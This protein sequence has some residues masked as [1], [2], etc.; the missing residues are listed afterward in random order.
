MF[1]QPLPDPATAYGQPMPTPSDKMLDTMLDVRRDP[2]GDP[3]WILRDD[4]ARHFQLTNVNRREQNRIKRA[5]KEIQMVSHW[6]NAHGLLSELQDDMFAGDILLGKSRGDKPDQMRERAW[7]HS[8]FQGIISKE[9]NVNK[10]AESKGWFG[11]WNKG[12]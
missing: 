12:Q 4:N 6:P 2:G 7:W 11:F 8:F 5:M 1:Q 3:I 9:G 10:P